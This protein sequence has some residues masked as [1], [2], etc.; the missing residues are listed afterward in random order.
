MICCANLCWYE[1]NFDD[2]RSLPMQILGAAEGISPV[3][4]YTYSVLMD[5]GKTND[6]QNHTHPPPPTTNEPIVM[7]RVFTW[8]HKPSECS[9][10]CGRGLLTLVPQCVDSMYLDRPPFDERFCRN[11]AKPLPIVQPCKIRDCPPE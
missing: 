10:T 7:D 3:V 1:F 9:R 4:S 2:V 8:R 11:V 5:E 6:H